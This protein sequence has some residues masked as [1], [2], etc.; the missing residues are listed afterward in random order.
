MQNNIDIKSFESFKTTTTLD[1][2]SMLEKQSLQSYSQIGGSTSAPEKKSSNP[3]PEKGGHSC[4]VKNIVCNT[5]TMSSDLDAESDENKRSKIVK[6]SL[7]DHYEWNIIESLIK[8]IDKEWKTD[9]LLYPDQACNLKIDQLETTSLSKDIKECIAEF[10]TEDL[11]LLN[12]IINYGGSSLLKYRNES[13]NNSNACCKFIHIY[14]QIFT[15][16]ALL[17][18]KTNNIAHR[19]IKNQNVVISEAIDEETGKTYTKAK[20][21]DFDLATNIN[22]RKSFLDWYSDTQFKYVYWPTDLILTDGKNGIREDMTKIF[23]QIRNKIDK[24]LIDDKFEA[25]KI[26]IIESWKLITDPNI[27]N[28]NNTSCWSN[29]N[30]IQDQLLQ[31][32]AQF[33]IDLHIHKKFETPELNADLCLAIQQNWDVYMMGIL[34]AQEYKITIDSKKTPFF[35]GNVEKELKDKLLAKFTFQNDLKQLILK[36]ISLHPINRISLESAITEYINIIKKLQ[37]DL[38]E[39]DN[40]SDNIQGIKKEDLIKIIERECYIDIDQLN[41]KNYLKINIEQINKC[42]LHLKE[43]DYIG[44]DKL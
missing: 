38:A 15:G 42:I 24:A 5:D 6:G 35:A 36:M 3:S 40:F 29:D 41:H 20:I 25:Y 16:L 4:V 39:I 19:D 37:F 30:D 23:N 31:T 12:M 34:L 17:K 11:E 21:I 27:C 32:S 18:S 22:R 26:A 2:S 28:I 9:Y 14:L 43:L 44:I 10:G 1:I 33:I 8:T 7:A 13:Q